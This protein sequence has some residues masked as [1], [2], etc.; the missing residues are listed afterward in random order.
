VTPVTPREVVRYNE[1]VTDVMLV[2]AAVAGD[3]SAFAQLVDRHARVCIRYA[4]RMLGNEQDAEDAAQETFVRAYRAL[5][6]FDESV[7]FRTWLMTILI[8]RCRSALDTR[9]RREERATS[10]AYE[11]RLSLVEASGDD[12]ALRDA[13]ERALEQLDPLQREA[14][15][16]KHVEDL[17]YDDMAKMTG[18]GVSALKMRVRR[19]CE[20][21]RALLEEERHA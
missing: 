10:V 4:T 15:L 6:R 20:H 16:L 13:I 1:A 21:L 5:A 17:S 12:I 18:A 19:A 14:F 3:A 2:R 8:N 11:A 9:R 7:A